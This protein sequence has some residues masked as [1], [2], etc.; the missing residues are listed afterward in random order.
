MLQKFYFFFLIFCGDEKMQ[1]DQ[2]KA[3]KGEE[4]SVNLFIICTCLLRSAISVS[5][6]GIDVGVG[7]CVD[8]SDRCLSVN[9]YLL[10]NCQDGG[11]ENKFFA[12]I[13]RLKY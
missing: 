1:K 3:R 6:S 8:V 13:L 10:L 2:K 4:Q 12:V 7:V 9:I 5:V 11:V